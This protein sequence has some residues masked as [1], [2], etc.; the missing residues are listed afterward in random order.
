MN[1]SAN[2][3][4]GKAPAACGTYQRCDIAQQRQS[5]LKCLTFNCTGADINVAWR[6]L[7][8]SNKI[9][10]QRFDEGVNQ[11]GVTRFTAQ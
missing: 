10:V 11:E 6:A 7:H 9:V 8:E 5:R 4:Q 1:I 2:V 3:A